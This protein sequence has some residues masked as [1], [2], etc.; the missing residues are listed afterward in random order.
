MFRSDSNKNFLPASHKVIPG[1][2]NKST[3]RKALI[4]V[5]LVS[6]FWGTI[7]IASREGVKYMPALQMAAIRQFIG[8]I[9][10]VIFFIS[11]GRAIPRGKEWLTVLIL[12]LLNF[13]LSNGLSTWG[14]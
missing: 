3:K 14:V 2:V 8:G 12:T 6:F 1:L 10:Y 9:L 13:V 5:G 7:W 4:A 11:K